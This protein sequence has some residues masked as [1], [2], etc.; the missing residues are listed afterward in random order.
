MRKITL[1]AFAIVGLTLKAQTT[2]SESI[3][4]MTPEY[5]LNSLVD[6]S[7]EVPAANAY[8]GAINSAKYASKF[9]LSAGEDFQAL[10]VETLVGVYN[11]PPYEIND[12]IEFEFVFY[13]DFGSEPG[14]IITSVVSPAESVNYEGQI[15]LTNGAI[16]DLYLITVDL[17][18]M[19]PLLGNESSETDY[20]FG[21]GLTDDDDVQ[22]GLNFTLD[23]TGS[24][25]YYDDGS[26]WTIFNASAPEGVSFTYVINGDCTPLSVEN[27]ILTNTFIYPNPTTDILN[28]QTPSNVTVQSVA[29]FDL[30]GKKVNV[31]FVNGTI[32]TSALA[33]GVYLLQVNTDQGT[34]TQ[35]IVKQ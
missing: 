26:G 1:V 27:N 8:G 34:L 5:T 24:L 25:T 3:V 20:F 29:M 30:L 10:S 16:V 18:S 15:T 19:T 12:D 28:I 2:L 21:I 11:N 31:S 35:K 23:A 7:V 13:E 33:K 22:I 6:C 4:S 9:T 17:T 14:D 32:K